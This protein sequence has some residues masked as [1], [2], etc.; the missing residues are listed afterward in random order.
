MT[1]IGFHELF[2]KVNLREAGLTF[3]FTLVLSFFSVSHSRAHK[4]NELLSKEREK[5]VCVW[6]GACW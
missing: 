4:L 1:Y 6:G 3:F 5:R 2:H